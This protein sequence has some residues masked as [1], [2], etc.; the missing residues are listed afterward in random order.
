[1]RW[2]VFACVLLLA[3]CTTSQTGSAGL[4][5]SSRLSPPVLV[6][7][8]ASR[9]VG[10]PCTLLKSSQPVTHDVIAGTAAGST[11]TWQGAKP[12]YPTYTATVDTTSGGLE[13]LYRNRSTLKFFEPTEIGGFPAVHTDPQAAAADHGRCTLTMGVADD[14]VITVVSTATDPKST[15]Y[16]SPCTDADALAHAIIATIKSGNA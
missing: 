11:C 9:F 3:A 16:S 10:A 5:S 13:T 15:N 1:M 8:D 7:L 2:A 4:S 14:S 6:P 12:R